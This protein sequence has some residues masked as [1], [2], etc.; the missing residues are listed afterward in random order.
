MRNGEHR[1]E[2]KG[3]L[4]HS[5]AAFLTYGSAMSGM[6][7]TLSQTAAIAGRMCW[8]VMLTGLLCN[9]PLAVWIL[10]L[11]SVKKDGTLF[12][13]LED[14]LGRAGSKIILFFYTLINLA[15]SACILNMFAGM[16]KVYFLPVTPL[17]VI[18]FVIIFMCT[19]FT[20]SGIQYFSRLIVLLCVLATVTY[21]SGYSVSFVNQF[22]M[23]NITPVFDGTYAQFAKGVFFVIGNSADCLLFL[24]VMVS[25]TPQTSR[26]Y[27]SIMK[28]LFAWSIILSL[29]T[30]ICEGCVGPDIWSNAAQGGISVS[31]VIQVGSFLSGLE[32][33][34]LMTYQFIV[35]IK[36]TIYLYSSWTS[37]KKMFNVPDGKPLLIVLALVL[38]IASAW[39]NSYNRGFF[40]SIFLGDYVILPFVILV[41]LLCTASA[42]VKKIRDGNKAK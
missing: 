7:Y 8:V 19:I 36:T 5:Q 14:G 30:F 31:T 32:V 17:A 40:Y 26:H 25:S 4:S 34:L 28:G 16:I 6:V 11:G 20:N 24:M 33:F 1:M 13:L 9:I 18:V 12:D 15:I 39:I 42:L 27:L 41:L 22:R 10:L 2:I 23:E 37:A 38:G 3:K 29:A 21:F 35:V